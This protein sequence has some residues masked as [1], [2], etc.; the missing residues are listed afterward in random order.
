MFPV[1]KNGTPAPLVQQPPMHPQLRRQLHDVLAALQPLDRH[2]LECLRMSPS[3]F[4][5][6]LQL[7][8][9]QV[10]QFLRWHREL[11][12][13]KWDHSDKRQ[14]VGR[15]RIRQQ[16]VDLALRM[17]RE[18]PSWGYDRIQGAL[19]NVGFHIS[20]TTV[21]N[22]LKAHGIEPAPERKSRTA[23]RTFLAAHWDSIAAAD[24]TTVEVW[25]R[26]RLH[27]HRDAFEDSAGRNRRGHTAAQRRLNDSNR[28][29]SDGL[30]RWFSSHSNSP[31]HRP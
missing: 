5:P 4:L 14:S 9:L 23:W 1:S 28:K 15:P 16:I 25:T 10:C 31:R 2:L 8:S 21:G 20:D 24:F 18:N 3:S 17:A 7:L 12:A 29:K 19:A 13:R 26:S 30:F 22:I 6:H 11:I 27:L